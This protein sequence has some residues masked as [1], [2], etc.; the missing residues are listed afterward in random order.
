MVLLA[1]QRQGALAGFASVG[2]TACRRIAIGE[3]VPRVGGM[4]MFAHYALENRH[5]GVDIAI[6]FSAK[7]VIAVVVQC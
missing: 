6:S 4:R 3:A 2:R 5:G 7:Q 1:R